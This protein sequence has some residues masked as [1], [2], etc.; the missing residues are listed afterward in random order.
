MKIT[1]LCENQVGYRGARS[2]R[3]EWGLSLFLELPG[4]RILFDTGA[5]EIYRKNSEALG[6]NLETTDM[7]ILSHHHWDHMGGLRHHP[8]N[9]KKS[10]LLHPDIP[11]KLDETDQ[12]LLERDFRTL[13][14]RDPVEIGENLLFL[15][16]I[17]R[18]NSFET[19][20]HKD[21]PMTDD[22]ALVYRSEEGCIVI[23]GCSH[24]GI[25]NICS[26]AQKISGQR[27]RAVIGGFHLMDRDSPAVEK[28][29]D[30]F[31][32]AGAVALYPLHCMSFPVQVLFHRH[33]NTEKLSTGDCISF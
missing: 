22:T 31:R 16:E 11:E 17:P 9:R 2:C 3:G 32:D 19:G 21:D 33:F 5:T 28:T 12:K 26:Y 7:I 23:S 10:L 29:I 27:L 4:S 13:Y 24:S 25:C 6:I 15:G 30:Y 14:S 8:F 18:E 1:V 20:V